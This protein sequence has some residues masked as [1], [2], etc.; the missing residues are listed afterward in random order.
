MYYAEARKKIYRV[1]F[2]RIE[3]RGQA[4]LYYAEARKKIYEVNFRLKKTVFS[5]FDVTFWA[6]VALY[7]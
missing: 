6:Y 4:C 1:N 7:T 2:R 3:S 5:V